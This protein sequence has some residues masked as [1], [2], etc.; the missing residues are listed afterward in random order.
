[1]VMISSTSRSYREKVI[2]RREMRRYLKMNSLDLK[3][4]SDDEK[5][6]IS[7]IILRT[8]LLIRN[9]NVECCTVFDDHLD[10][11][12]D[13]EAI[14][15]IDHWRCIDIETKKVS[16]S[17]ALVKPGYNTPDKRVEFI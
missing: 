14:I 6:I 9:G 1:M 2:Y 17:M 13:N 11:C 8:G 15:R 12:T 7:F 3:D 10:I 5:D 16:Y 4:L